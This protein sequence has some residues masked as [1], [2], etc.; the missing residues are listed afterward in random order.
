MEFISAMGN[1]PNLFEC[2]LLPPSQLDYQRGYIS[3][4]NIFFMTR[5]NS[6]RLSLEQCPSFQLLPGPKLHMTDEVTFF[7]WGFHIENFTCWLGRG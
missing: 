5:P 4:A 3:N 6:R 1:V 2:S 7:G